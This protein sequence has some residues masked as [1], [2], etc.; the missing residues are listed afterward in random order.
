MPLPNEQERELFGPLIPPFGRNTNPDKKKVLLR[1]EDLEYDLQM[2]VYDA[3]ANGYPKDIRYISAE[4]F[5]LL[6]KDCP[7][8]REEFMEKKYLWVISEWGLRIILEATRNIA[9]QKPFVCHTNLTGGGEAY[10]GGELWFC[11]DGRAGINFFSDRYGA[12]T[13]KQWRAVVGYFKRVGYKN[14]VE[15]FK[16]VK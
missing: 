11:E 3:T 2:G 12:Q 16:P 10:Q 15:L 1:G 8:Y 6:L 5:N 7:K 13:Q 9:R 4:N 14:V